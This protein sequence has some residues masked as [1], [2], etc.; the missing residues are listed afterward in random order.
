M[1]SRSL[2]ASAVFAWPEAKIAVMSAEAAVG[3]LHRKRLAAAH[4]D[5]ERAELRQRLIAE[6]TLVAGVSPAP[7]RWASSTK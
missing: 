2:G 3:I 6:H 7:W 5:D 4:D 1:N